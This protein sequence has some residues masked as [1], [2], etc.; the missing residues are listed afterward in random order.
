MAVCE[1]L[2]ELYETT[3]GNPASEGFPKLLRFTDRRTTKSPSH[4]P[5]LPSESGCQGIPD[6]QS[7]RQ[8]PVPLF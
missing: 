8:C 2:I 3:G 7:R 4:P 5:G 6:D 1:E